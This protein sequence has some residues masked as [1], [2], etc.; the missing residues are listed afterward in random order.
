[1][2]TCPNG[3]RALAESVYVE[4]EPE[5]FLQVVVEQYRGRTGVAD[6]TACVR[7]G[8]KSGRPRLE[9]RTDPDAYKR[10]NY[11]YGRDRLERELRGATVTDVDDNE[12][13]IGFEG[14]TVVRAERCMECETT[15]HAHAVLG[16][17]SQQPEY[18]PTQGDEWVAADLI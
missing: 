7:G 9:L 18:E 12:V 6:I 10:W 8:Q 5:Q 11:F 3:C 16:D 14:T 17:V 1:M 13:C 15:V 2:T 4:V